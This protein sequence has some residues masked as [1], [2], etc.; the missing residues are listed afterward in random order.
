MN[1]EK[2]YGSEFHWR[3]IILGAMLCLVSALLPVSFAYAGEGLDRL[4]RFTANLNSMKADFTQ[5]LFD[6]KMRQVEVASGFFLL[7][8]PGKFRWDYRVPYQQLI[9][10]NGEKLW[11]YDNDLEQ[12]TVKPLEE[13]LGAAPI[14]LLTGSDDLEK[15]FKIIELGNIDGR[16]FLQLEL[17][18]KD[19]DYGFMLLAMG[20]KG[21]EVMELKD[22]LGQVTR[23]EFQNIVLNAKVSSD[24]FE[25]KVPEGVDV[26][27]E[28]A[29]SANGIS[30]VQT[31]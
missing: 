2:K 8:K 4:K 27:G 3:Q 1:K 7:Q 24:K 9:V 25:F 14:T 11:L 18:V 23:I 6:D 26:I 29:P 12:V 17:K 20:K 5:T 30:A 28:A 16:E 10:A 21:L 31:Q 19:T 15:Q 22:K 13:A